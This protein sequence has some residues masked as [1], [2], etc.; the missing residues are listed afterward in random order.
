MGGL[1]QRY[2]LIDAPLNESLD[3]VV[4]G[5]PLLPIAFLPAPV[6]FQPEVPA[7]GPGHN[8]ALSFD[9]FLDGKV[10]YVEIPYPTNGDPADQILITVDGI[11][12]G[13]GNLGPR[14]GPF[15]LELT[16]DILD[17]A[18]T[19]ATG[20]TI[21]DISYTLTRGGN[22]PIPAPTRTIFVNFTF[23]G[24]DPD[25]LPNLDNENL[26]AVQVRGRD[27]AGD[28]DHLT[29]ADINQPVKFTVPRWAGLPNLTEAATVTYYWNRVLLNT[30]TLLNS[31][32][33]T[34]LTVPYS[35]ISP[36]GLGSIPATYTLEYPGNP[37]VM[38]KTPPTDV[39][40]E[41]FDID[42]ETHTGP[43]LQLAGDRWIA[44]ESMVPRIPN[45][46]GTYTVPP[47][48]VSVPGGQ[49]DTPPN[50]DV[51]MRMNAWIDRFQSA[52]VP[53]GISYDATQP[54][55]A[56]N[57]DNT[58]EMPFALFKAIQL[59]APVATPIVTY[60][61]EIW[62]EITLGGQTYPSTHVMHPVR[63]RNSSQQ[64]CDQLPPNPTP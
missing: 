47:L 32:T 39:L 10:P 31:D 2:K 41:T 61:A 20:E 55:P 54:M 30:S 14:P 18:T 6:L 12:L 3:S 22:P 40:V 8:E 23:P 56:G 37:N 60:Y 9:S 49:R 64:Y 15:R 53:G 44:C 5:A 57:A 43:F 16:Y 38:R 48:R 19:G 28:L 35:Q 13:S 52:P 27:G 1:F 24:P 62:Y 42:L 51:R 33:E 58:F 21:V 63:A 36:A 45:G 17:E 46:D 50:R 59:A 34:S 26:I 7:A 25:T 29:S 4:A 11:P